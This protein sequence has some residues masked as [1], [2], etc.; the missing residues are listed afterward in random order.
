MQLIEKR[1]TNRIS[2]NHGTPLIEIK[3]SFG[4]QK[5]SAYQIKE[6]NEK[7]LSFLVP[8]SEGYFMTNTPIQFNINNNGSSRHNLTGTVKYYQPH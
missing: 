1:A 8:K 5:R 7:G 6:H 2:D 3:H 4:T